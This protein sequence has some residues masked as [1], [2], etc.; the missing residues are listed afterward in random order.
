MT[1]TPLIFQSG[2][3]QVTYFD[4]IIDI[5]SEPGTITFQFRNKP[6]VGLY[7]LNRDKGFVYFVYKF[8]HGPY[9]SY[10]PIGYVHPTLTNQNVVLHSYN[11]EQ[12]L[13][14]LVFLIS[15][16]ETNHDRSL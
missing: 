8:P 16:M 10:I 5:H 9:S 11:L 12:F 1:V 13:D 4:H 14:Y 3:T 6:G 7:L 2:Q 15:V